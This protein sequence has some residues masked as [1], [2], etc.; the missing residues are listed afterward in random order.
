MKFDESLKI[1]TRFNDLV[2]GGCHTYAKGDDQYPEFMPVYI[3]RGKGSHVWDIDGNEYIEYGMGLRTVTLGHAFGPVVEA[4]RRQMLLG[5][6]FVRPARIELE[7][8]EKFLSIIDRAEMVKFCKDGSDATS[9]AVKLART[10][11]G[12]DMV[13][14]CGDH[15]FFSVDDWFIG[16]T[17][18]SAGI[19]Q[20]VKDLTV[21]FRYND[22]ESVRELFETYPGKIACV[23]LEAEKTEPPKDGYLG[24]LLR[25]AHENGALF[26]LDEMITGFRWHLG[27]A[28]K[29]YEIVPDLSAFGKALANGFALSALAGRRD[30]MERGGLHHDKERVFLMSTT[31]G[32]ENH[33]LAAAL[34]TMTYYQDHPVVE[35]LYAQ[36]RKLADGVNRA[37]R[38]LGLEEQVS[39]IGPDC[40]S[41]YTT[42]DQEKKPSQPF[43]TLFL[44]ETMKRGL[45]MPSSIVSYAH[46]D[47]DIATTVERIAEALVIY[48]KALDEGIGKY[49]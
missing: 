27:G 15:P 6:N 41:V 31:H 48:R 2:P 5:N 25:I 3:A 7:C 36:G 18:I 9:G 35:T 28:Q 24:E 26:I 19:P 13:A 8:A 1:Q 43:R 34:A 20:C 47:T 44:Q 40:C 22:L 46:S 11:T 32:A 30:V 37:S 33:A 39:I 38:E 49:L 17:A 4:A 45:L 16:S 21:K 23:I 14:I 10:F 42:R 29:K 12:R